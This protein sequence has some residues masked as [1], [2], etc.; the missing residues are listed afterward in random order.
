MLHHLA[1]VR[2]YILKELI[3]SIIKVTRIIQLGTTL[4]VVL[5]TANVPSS[6]ILVTLMMEVI[7]SSE[8]S[9][10]T[11]V[12]WCNIAED[13]ILHAYHCENLKSYKLNTDSVFT[14][15]KAQEQIII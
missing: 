12:T 4:A 11:R 6:P 9:V 15:F 10:F 7:S 14:Y 5:V 2:T 1:L 13:D 8:T 3:A